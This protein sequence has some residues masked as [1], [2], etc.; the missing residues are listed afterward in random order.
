VQLADLDPDERDLLRTVA[1]LLDRL[2][3]QA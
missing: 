2:A 3:S 1:P